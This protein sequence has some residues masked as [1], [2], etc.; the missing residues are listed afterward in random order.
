M[1]VMTYKPKCPHCLSFSGLVWVVPDENGWAIDADKPFHSRRKP[2][3]QLAPCVCHKG[4]KQLNGAKLDASAKYKWR[5]RN[6]DYGVP[7]MSADHRSGIYEMIERIEANWSRD[8]E[9]R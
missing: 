3:P 2:E 4:Y 6:A 1:L 8:G 7:E 5:K 9:N